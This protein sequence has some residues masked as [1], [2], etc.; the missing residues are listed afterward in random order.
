[1]STIRLLSP[2]SIIVLF[3]L[4]LFSVLTQNTTVVVDGL[5]SM[6]NFPRLK[7]L[8]KWTKHTGWCEPRCDVANAIVI[9]VMFSRTVLRIRQEFGIVLIV[10]VLI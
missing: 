4:N 9:W 3:V 1:M 7:S 10:Q 2:E 8:K 6:M 5:H